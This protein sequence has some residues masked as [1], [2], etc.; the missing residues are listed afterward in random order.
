MIIT[1][2]KRAFGDYVHRP[3]R[4]LYFNWFLAVISGVLWHGQYFSF[5]TGTTKVGE[6]SYAGWSIFMAAIIIFSNLWGLV[7]REWK[8]VDGKT[9]G[10]LCLGIFALVVSVVMIGVGDGLARRA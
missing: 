9:R 8:L 3:R 4:T 5:G 10:Y 6:Y 1:A 2:R 7:L